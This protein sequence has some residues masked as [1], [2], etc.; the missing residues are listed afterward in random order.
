MLKVTVIVSDMRVTR[1][2]LFK[3]DAERYYVGPIDPNSTA[4][5]VKGDA[6]TQ[7][8]FATCKTQRCLNALLRD[9]RY[10]V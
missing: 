1:D 5:N 8:P 10:S 9:A 7:A 4:T 3:L 2:P 6:S